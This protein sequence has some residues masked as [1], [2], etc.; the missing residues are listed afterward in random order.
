MVEHCKIALYRAR[1]NGSIIPLLKWISIL[2]V[3]QKPIFKLLKSNACGCGI[4]WMAYNLR[5]HGSTQ[6][7]F[8]QDSGSNMHAK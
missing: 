4:A 1:F 3:S 8:N 6:Q 5:R 2:S 7:K